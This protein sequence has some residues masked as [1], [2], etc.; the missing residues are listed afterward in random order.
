MPAGMLSQ[1]GRPVWRVDSQGSAP[2]AVAE[3][4]ALGTTARLAIWPAQSLRRAIGAVDRELERLDLAASRFRADSELSRI[5]R[6]DGRG[7]EVSAGLAEAVRV[8]LTAA[9][10][11]GGLV[12]PTV[13]SA[14]IALGYDRDFAEL[15]AR[16]W[17]D[18]AITAAEI[19]GW[20][21]VRL[22][23]SLLH[24]PA[25]VR[26]D[27]GA[28]AK[29]LGADWAARAAHQASEAGGVL[30]SLG[31]DMATVGDC[32]LGGWPVLVADDHRQPDWSSSSATQ[33]IRLTGGG[34]ATSSI[35]CRQWERSGQVLHHIVDP[36]TG[37]PASG[38]WRTVSVAAVTCASANAAST[39]AIIGG[40]TA[41]GWLAAHGLAA[42][43][44]RHDGSVLHVGGWPAADDGQLD[45]G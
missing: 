9:Q 23:G 19:P 24:L 6:G 40:D 38:P 22:D 28:T 7:V 39:A 41:P 27:L 5:H 10:W 45:P 11:T 29:G 21:R 2:V 14:L 33:L 32:P 16:P 20:Q 43:L 35:L 31:G 8:A 15:S 42:R 1:T 3:R 37:L 44:V 30:V 34:L 4:D 17:A 36:R 26:L 25:G 18:Q 12:D 13:G